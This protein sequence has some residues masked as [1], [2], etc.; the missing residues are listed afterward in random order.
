MLNMSC[1]VMAVFVV[2]APAY[3]GIADAEGEPD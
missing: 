2:K 1:A 3:E